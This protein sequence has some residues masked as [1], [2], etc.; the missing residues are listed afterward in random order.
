MATKKTFYITTAIDYVNARPHVG[1][2][3]EK[4]LADALARYKRLQ[5]F[6]VF[7][8][9]GVDENAQKNV[10]AAQKEGIPVKEFIDRNTA[11]FVELCKKLNLSH[12]AFIRT[13]AKEHIV[14]VQK[15]IK[16]VIDKGDI[17][18][19]AYEGLYCTGCET[20][21]TE[22]DLINGK[23]PEHN[24]APEV[25]RE[26]AYFFKLSKYKKFLLDLYKENPEFILPEERKNEIENRVK[27]ELRDVCIS[28]KGAKWG[29]DFPD[30]K[31]YKIWVWIDALINYISGL[32]KN[33]SKYWPAD[34]HVI[35]K[36]INWF[37]TVI[38]PALLKS[39]GYK[40]PEHIMV[41]GYFKLGGHKMSKSLGNIV[42]PLVLLEKYP[43]DSVRYSMLKCSVFDD[44][45]FDEE[46]FIKRHNNEL[47][48]KLGNL[49][50][51][52]STLA[53]KYGI[54]KA[55]QV[56]ELDSKEII[57]KTKEHFENYQFDKALNEIFAYIDKCNTYV[58]DTSPWITKDKKVLYRL[59]DAIKDA[60]ILLAPIIPETAEKIAQTFNFKIA[61]EELGKP[62]K[63]TKIKKSDILFK[64]I[65]LHT[66]QGGASQQERESPQQE[67]MKKEKSVNNINNEAEL[68]VGRIIDVKDHT[69]ADKLYVLK[70][71]LAEKTGR[72]IVAGLKQHYKK[73]ELINQKAVFVTNL[74]PANLRGIESN[75]MIL[76]ASTEDKSKVFFLKPKSE[77][78]EGTKVE[79]KN[80]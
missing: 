75:G 68:K 47:A 74:K 19:S 7:F 63:V 71:D 1:H 16:K 59:A 4:T 45:D 51:R 31:E 23:C 2:A 58:Q 65:D 40:L 70:V 17:Y 30:D 48:D 27:E 37:H 9:T 44:S 8:L 28:R 5:G 20:Y 61:L 41:H 54:E 69:N 67:R 79:I 43:S 21:Y 73:E 55:E 18:K 72:T 33:E 29:V 62:I 49:V 14:V 22:K 10:E 3:F 39:A 24:R 60:T 77:V 26:E 57:K 42:D 64:K 25:R 12:D 6:D 38:W 11:Y 32:G 56:K 80:G 15:I 53:E 50:S 34:V 36:G 46:I 66:P 78:P 52:V 35:G 76:A 13:T